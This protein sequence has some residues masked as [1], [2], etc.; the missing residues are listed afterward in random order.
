MSNGN[1]AERSGGGEIHQVKDAQLGQLRKVFWKPGQHVV[2]HLRMSAIS[3]LARLQLS[4]YIDDGQCS[5]LA[6]QL[7]PDLGNL[8]VGPDQLG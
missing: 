4:T 2:V 1:L 5:K 3:S 6:C 8:V 7:V